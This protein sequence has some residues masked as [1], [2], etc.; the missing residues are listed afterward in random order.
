MRVCINLIMLVGFCFFFWITRFEFGMLTSTDVLCWL[1]AR[2]CARLRLSRRDDDF[3]LCTLVKSVR[4]DLR[5]RGFGCNSVLSCMWMT[6]AGVF[7]HNYLWY[8]PLQVWVKR[9]WLMS[10]IF[11]SFFFFVVVSR[12]KKRGIATLQGGVF[13]IVAPVGSVSFSLC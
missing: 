3:V 4:V 2:W 8:T 1:F 9:H 13:G 10:V 11:I 5:S 12:F 6:P 7:V